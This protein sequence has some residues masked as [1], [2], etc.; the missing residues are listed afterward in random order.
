MHN[1]IRPNGFTLVEVLV[2]FSIVAVLMALLLPSFDKSRE[3]ARRTVCGTN[4]RQLHIAATNYSNDFKLYPPS[5][6]GNGNWGNS[7]SALCLVWN[8]FPNTA[9]NDGQTTPTGLWKLIHGVKSAK[10]VANAG[11]LN[12]DYAYLNNYKGAQCPSMDVNAYR[13]PGSFTATGYAIDYDYRYNNCDPAAYGYA[14]NT[15]YRTDALNRAPPW[16]PLFHDGDNYRLYDPAGGSN[17]IAP[18]PRSLTGWNAKWSH[19]EGGNVVRTDGAVQ[20]VPNKINLT[21]GNFYGNAVSWP[22][23]YVFTYYYYSGGV[24][25]G[26]NCLDVIMRARG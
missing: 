4:V 14:P 21:T 23:G 8:S 26:V 16:T 20:F 7:G 13:A 6:G 2:V 22:S 10:F 1:R 19:L 17:A 25:N 5:P 11:K 15:Q 18:R 3:F 24:G 9:P 12:C